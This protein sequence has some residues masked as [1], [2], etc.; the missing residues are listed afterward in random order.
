MLYSLIPIGEFYLLI[1][2]SGYIGSYLTIAAVAATALLGLAITSK[3]LTVVL[4]EVHLRIESGT[5]PEE[6]LKHL[7]GTLIAGVLVITPGVVTELVGFLFF[8]PILRRVIG[9]AAVK[10]MQSRLKELYEYVK[11]YDE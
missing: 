4:R 10:P 6:A 7:A 1:V 2:I 11:L 5:Y 3:S 8:I 9:T